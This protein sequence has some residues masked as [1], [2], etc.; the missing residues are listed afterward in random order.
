MKRKGRCVVVGWNES[1]LSSLHAVKKT[2]N[3]FR[4]SSE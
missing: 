1:S 4:N 3:S 2:K